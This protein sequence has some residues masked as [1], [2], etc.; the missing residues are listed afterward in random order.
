MEPAPL[1]EEFNTNENLLKPSQFAKPNNSDIINVNDF[2][3]EPKNQ[4]NLSL[5]NDKKSYENDNKFII[6][7]TYYPL[8]SIFISMF[9]LIGTI[10]LSILIQ[11]IEIYIRIIILISGISIILII[12]IITNNR[13]EITKNEL[14]NKI[15][16]KIINLLCFCKKKMVLGGENARFFTKC[17]DIKGDITITLIIINDY[18]NLID[19]DLDTSNIKHKPAKF[20]YYFNHI[21]F[22][23][24]SSYEELSEKLNNFIAPG[25]INKNPLLSKII[26]DIENNPN[27]LDKYMKFSEHFST[28]NVI[29]SISLF[30]C[31][32]IFNF[33]FFNVIAFSIAIPFLIFPNFKPHIRIV[34]IIIVPLLNIMIFIF[35][36]FIQIFL[37]NIIRIDFIYS[38][39]FDRIFIGL[40]KYNGTSYS[41]TYQFNMID[42]DKFILQQQGQK[43]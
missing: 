5:F 42:I 38:K 19:I 10:L 2:F 30:H 23:K 16:I 34:G 14:N 4:K 11:R 13:L 25:E 28:F 43:K 29:S 1:N 8:L 7:F 35:F 33:I 36:K 41:R 32:K 17:K 24:N 18:Y 27:N 21:L 31:C 40:V 15:N 9:I 12:F 39:N 6:R 22:E 20:Y 37:F 26:N 3:I